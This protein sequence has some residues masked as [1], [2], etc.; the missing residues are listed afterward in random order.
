MISSKHYKLA[1]LSVVLISGAVL[2]SA[3][4]NPSVHAR[5]QVMNKVSRT[6]NADANKT[7]YAVRS[8]LKDGG[9]PITLEDLKNG[10]IKTGWR[11]SKA[12]SFYLN[13]FGHTD[14]G[15]NGAYYMFEINIVPDDSGSRV[16]VDVI[17]HVK[18]MASPLLTSEIYEKK[19]LKKIAEY[20][21]PADIDVTNIGI[22][23]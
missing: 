5:E 6:F 16:A 8:S 1:L 2:L 13:P 23:E 17:S 9:Y 12:D 11:A 4:A 7:Y 19:L 22:I 21:R 15:A 3:C 20:L 18:S 10:V 14:Y